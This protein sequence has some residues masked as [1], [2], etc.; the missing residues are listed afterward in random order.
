M[1][2]PRCF[3]FFPLFSSSD[4]LFSFYNSN[5]RIITSSYVIHNNCMPSSLLW[6]K[7][8]P[9]SWR[10]CPM[11]ELD[12]NQLYLTQCLLHYL[13]E[14]RLMS[15]LINYYLKCKRSW[16]MKNLT[17]PIYPLLEL[18]V[19]RNTS[20]WWF[21]TRPNPSSPLADEWRLRSRSYVQ[22]TMDVFRV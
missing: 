14:S 12:P 4:A 15:I 20:H 5:L 17:R 19:C 13:S 11:L 2:P 3:L 22:T 21:K 16:G 7:S 10:P 8:L 9:P 6:S 18:I 1:S